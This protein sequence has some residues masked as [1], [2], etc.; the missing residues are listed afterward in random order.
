MPVDIPHGEVQQS[1]GLAGVVDAHHVRV[2]ECR[3]R[4]SLAHE[5]LAEVLVGGQLWREDLDRRWP[6]QTEVARA[7]DDAHAATA[8]L[9]LEQV[10]GDLAAGVRAG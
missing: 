9:V 7:V 5:A 6:S 4:A 3:R 1:V 10:P 2:V 8:E